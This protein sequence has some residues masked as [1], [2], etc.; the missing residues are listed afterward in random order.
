[1]GYD[2]PHMPKGLVR[3]QHTGHFHFIPFSYSRCQPSLRAAASR[4]LFERS[5]ETMRTR[6]SF[7]VAG[8]VVMPEH[9]HTLVSEPAQ[10]VL[11]KAIQALKLSVSVQSIHHPFWQIR[12]YDFNVYAPAKRA[13]KIDRR[14]PDFPWGCSAR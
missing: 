6:Y 12:Y 4:S 1:M 5:L 13:E 3:H 8:F 14:L 9:I 11:G 2:G 7:V 10:A